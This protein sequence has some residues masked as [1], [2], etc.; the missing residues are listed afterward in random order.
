MP[1][2]H[3]SWTRLVDTPD[4]E[5]PLYQL[6]CLIYARVANASRLALSDLDDFP[7]VP[8]ERVEKLFAARD[9]L[10]PSDP[11]R[12]GL[13]LFF[14]A[15]HTCPP[16]VCPS[17]LASWARACNATG[18]MDGR[19]AHHRR[20]WKPYVVPG[21]TWDLHTHGF[22][23]SSRLVNGSD[24]PMHEEMALA[25]QGRTGEWC[26][27]MPHGVEAEAAVPPER[28]TCV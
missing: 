21:N 7:P 28:W 17:S 20:V 24:A 9:A 12:W 4:F 22:V 16:G 15:E 3:T 19:F 14:D 10:P 8:H 1:W 13:R 23:T 11:R 6:A 5:Q 25:G 27:C 26:P 2:H 18:T